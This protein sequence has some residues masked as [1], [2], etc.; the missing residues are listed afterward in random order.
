MT[1]GI[2][3]IDGAGVP[4][5]TWGVDGRCNMATTQRR[6]EPCRVTAS[7]S[8][9]MREKLAARAAVR[10]D[11][12]LGYTEPWAWMHPP[13]HALAALLAEQGH[14]AE[15]EEV[16]RDDLGLSGRIQR[17]TQHP[18]NV[19]ALHGIVECLRRRG[20]KEEHA[21]LSKKLDDALALADVPITSSCMCRATVYAPINSGRDCCS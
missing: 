19:W 7:S 14:Y 9:L 15:A 11:D 6:Y 2:G 5:G 18:D 10:R 4:P 8:R 20:E 21:R 12:S 3:V 1:C 16:Y 17:C 13:R